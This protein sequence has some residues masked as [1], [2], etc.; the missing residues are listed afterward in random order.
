M[1]RAQRLSRLREK[2]NSAY[3]RKTVFLGGNFTIAAEDA[4]LEEIAIECR[5]IAQLADAIRSEQQ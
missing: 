5:L 1:T 3:S 2:V 4:A